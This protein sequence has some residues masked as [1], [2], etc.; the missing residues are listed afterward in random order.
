MFAPDIDDPLGRE[1]CRY[2][3]PA[4][5]TLGFRR[6]DDPDPRLRAAGS[7]QV[8]LDASVPHDAISPGTQVPAKQNC[9]VLD[10]VAVGGLNTRS[11]RLTYDN[12]VALHATHSRDFA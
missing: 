10:C 6:V 9:S 8:V 12:G 4:L 11:S 3:R 7:V 5:A 2:L 1:H